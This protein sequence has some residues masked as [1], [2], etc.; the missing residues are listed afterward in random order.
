M[1]IDEVFSAVPESEMSR[2]TASIV[3]YGRALEE[4][5]LTVAEKAHQVIVSISIQRELS[6]E[7]LPVIAEYFGK[8]VLMVIKHSV[9]ITDTELSVITAL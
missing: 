2:D 9:I 7:T 6:F 4:I 8:D 5:Y 3:G 1:Q